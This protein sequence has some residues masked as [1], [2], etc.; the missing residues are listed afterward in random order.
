L[1]KIPSQFARYDDFEGETGSASLGLSRSGP[2]T[3][4]SHLSTKAP[5]LVQR[6]LY[7]EHKAPGMAHI[8][9]MSSAGG[10]LQ[11]DK[12]EII[13]DAG[14]NTSSRITT[15]AATKIYKMEHGFASQTVSLC[16]HPGSYVEFLP[17]QL[18]PFKSSRFYQE[19]TLAVS[20][21]STVVYSETLSGGRTASGENFAFDVCFLRMTAREMNGGVL[22]SDVCCM[23]P[24]KMRYEL[25]FGGKTIWSTIYVITPRDHESIDRE[26]MEIIGRHGILAGCSKLPHDCGLFVRILDDSIDRVR[27]LTVAVARVARKHAVAG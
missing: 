9:L 3:V 25:L 2:R 16:A 24:E 12:M 26:I 18:I 17:H 15:Q 13:V 23:E 4:L 8:Y 27:D 5:L 21:E 19:V 14:K 7:P 22:F 20:P 11:G 10:I 1:K 6:A